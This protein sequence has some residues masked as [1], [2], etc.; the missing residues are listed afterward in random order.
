[1]RSDQ[2][3][4]HNRVVAEQNEVL[5]GL[6]HYIFHPHTWKIEDVCYLRDLYVAPELRGCGVGRTL[7]EAVHAVSDV[8]GVS[9]V[10]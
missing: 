4:S 6:V 7:I 3:L 10:Y 8:D 1:M 2:N 9:N 5:V